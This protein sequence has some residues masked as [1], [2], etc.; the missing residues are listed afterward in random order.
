MTDEFLTSSGSCRLA[1]TTHLQI[2]K[3][4]TFV[5]IASISVS[6]PETMIFKA[7]EPAFVLGN[8]IF[9]LMRN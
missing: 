8:L 2:L 4:Q 6:H 9:P 1:P 5:E 3:I 7:S